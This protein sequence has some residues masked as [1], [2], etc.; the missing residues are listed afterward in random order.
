MMAT[1]SDRPF[2]ISASKYPGCCWPKA[3]PSS[4]TS[5]NDLQP[6]VAVVEHPARVVVDD[7]AERGQLVAE[8]QDLVHLL[9]VLGDDDRH[10]GVG[11]HVLASSRVIE[12]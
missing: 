5:A 4:W 3:R 2:S 8:R 7:E 1:S 6:V 11:P 10:V 9:L 12:S